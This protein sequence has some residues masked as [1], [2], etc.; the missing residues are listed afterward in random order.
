[1]VVSNECRSDVD[2][3]V[4]NAI[5]KCY[6]KTDYNEDVFFCECDVWYGWIGKSCDEETITVYFSRVL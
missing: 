5:K 2:C 4:D 1:M 3:S 6:E